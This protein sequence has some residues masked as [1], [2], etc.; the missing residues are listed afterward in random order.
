M[1]DALAR[2][3]LSIDL[4]RGGSYSCVNTLA[5]IINRGRGPLFP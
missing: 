4:G 5:R 2:L 3:K 1:L